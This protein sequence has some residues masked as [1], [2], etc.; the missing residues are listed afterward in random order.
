MRTRHRSRRSRSTTDNPD[1]LNEKLRIFD[2]YDLWN[3][4]DILARII[5]GFWV[6]LGPQVGSC[7]ESILEKVATGIEY[8]EPSIVLSGRDVHKAYMHMWRNQGHP[9]NSIERWEPV[10]H[11]YLVHDSSFSPA[12]SKVYD[13]S[14]HAKM[15]GHQTLEQIA[16]VEGKDRANNLKT[17]VSSEIEERWQRITSHA[18]HEGACKV[19]PPASDQHGDHSRSA[20]GEGRSVRGSSES[21]ETV[22]S[23]DTGYYG[24]DDGSYSSLST[25]FGS[26]DIAGGRGRD[27]GHSSRHTAA[28]RHRITDGRHDTDHVANERGADGGHSGRHSTSTRFSITNGRHDNDRVPPET[29]LVRTR[30]RVVDPHRRSRAGVDGNAEAPRRRNGGFESSGARYL[31][32]GR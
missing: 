7:R 1:D 30:S 27:P 17:C 9:H 2:H 31:E 23:I 13:I 22:A 10:C 3:N 18:P 8:Y 32:R 21:S 29:V 16:A 20:R 26:L 6:A 11:A 24:D 12:S 15:L 28:P 4:E 14:K 25:G 5:I 19:R